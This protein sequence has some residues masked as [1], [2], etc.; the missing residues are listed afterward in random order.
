VF[1]FWLLLEAEALTS[2]ITKVQ[3]YETTGARTGRWGHAAIAW[4]IGLVVD[5][6]DG[7][8][9]LRKADLS[10]MDFGRIAG[11]RTPQAVAL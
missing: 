6:A 4:A 5:M 3:P 8:V 7:A 9:D 2:S 10:S 1:V 11:R